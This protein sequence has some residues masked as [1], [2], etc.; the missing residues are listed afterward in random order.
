MVVSSFQMVVY[1]IDA[2]S[3]LIVADGGL[4]A[5]RCQENN[6]YGSCW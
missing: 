1:H 2:I 3:I 5:N 4:Y 6:A